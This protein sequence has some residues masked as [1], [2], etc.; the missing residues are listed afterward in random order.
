MTRTRTCVFT[1]VSPMPWRA[2]SIGAAARGLG[3]ELRHVGYEGARHFK[4]EGLRGAAPQ[5]HFGLRQN[6]TRTH[7]DGEGAF[8]EI[9]RTTRGQEYRC[10]RTPQLAAALAVAHI[11]QRVWNAR[12]RLFKR[13]PKCRT[14]G[15]RRNEQ[16]LIRAE[17]Q[18]RA[19]AVSH[20]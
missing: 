7:A 6:G 18:R 11:D 1:R 3:N 10:L 16:P 8:I 4:A 5:H 9:E 15:L 19:L 14:L 2:A 17:P 13:A 12:Q 20:G